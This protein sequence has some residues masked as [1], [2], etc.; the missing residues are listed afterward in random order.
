MGDV[1]EASQVTVATL[2][3]RGLM[4]LETPLHHRALLFWGTGLWNVINCNAGENATECL[5]RRHGP[6]SPA[7]ISPLIELIGLVQT[8]NK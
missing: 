5:N 7:R 4:T 6:S 8:E 3:A 2:P 1:R